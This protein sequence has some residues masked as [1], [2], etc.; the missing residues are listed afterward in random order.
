M[1]PAGPERAASAALLSG[2]ACQPPA[3]AGKTPLSHAAAAT[4]LHPAPPAWEAL[5]GPL[6]A[7][8]AEATGAHSLR[9]AVLIRQSACSALLLPFASRSAR[10]TQ[11]ECTSELKGLASCMRQQGGSGSDPRAV[12]ACADR[13]L[14]FDMCTEEF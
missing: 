11:R 8:S 7:P 2:R 13:F 12:S 3:I 1:Q 14:A 9:I 10:F 5:H 4:S 6:P